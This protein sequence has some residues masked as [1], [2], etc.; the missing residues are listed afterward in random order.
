MSTLKTEKCGAS[1]AAIESTGK[2]PKLSRKNLMEKA[3]ERPFSSKASMTQSS[4]ESHPLY[5]AFI[6]KLILED[7]EDSQEIFGDFG[8]YES[9]DEEDH[10]EIEGETCHAAT[11]IQEGGELASHGAQKSHPRLLAHGFSWGSAKI[12]RMPSDRFHTIAE[13]D[14]EY[15]V[16]SKVSGQCSISDSYPDDGDAMWRL[17]LSETLDAAVPIAERV[18]K[19]YCYEEKEG[20]VEN[21]ERLSA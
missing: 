20:S 14:E 7:F 19:M 17:Q 21:F 16:K 4:D 3:R 2:G 12:V 18:E 9:G 13:D 8:D 15:D 1:A 11:T 6:D 10:D 5:F